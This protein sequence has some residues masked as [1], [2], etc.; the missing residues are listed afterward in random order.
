MKAG[1]WKWSL[2]V[3][4]QNTVSQKLIQLQDTLD[5]NVNIV[6]WCMWTATQFNEMPEIVLRKAIASTQPWNNEV[7]TSLRKARRHMKNAPDEGGDLI[8]AVKRAE[9]LSERI[10]QEKLQ[11]F[12]QNNLSYCRVIDPISQARNHLA[13]YLRLT[14]VTQKT[15]YSAALIEALLTAIFTPERSVNKVSK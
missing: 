6:L 12:A 1:F 2:E 10:E 5:L 7:T 9:L 14:G 8:K 3:Y 4:G 13:H 15:G 11:H